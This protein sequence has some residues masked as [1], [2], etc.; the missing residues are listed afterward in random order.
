[1]AERIEE[2]NSLYERAL[3]DDGKLAELVEQL[4]Q[5]NRR[6][7]QMAGAA[8]ALVAKEAPMRLIAHASSLIEALNLPEAQTRWECLDALTLIAGCDARACDKA[9]VG[10]ETALF[11][12]DSGPV[13]LA[14][15]RFLCKYGSTTSTRSEKVWPLIDEAIQC[16]H[17]DLEFNDMLTAITDF[18]IG[19]LS[20]SVKQQLAERM[21]F[22]AVNGKG[23]LQRRAAQIV[24]NVTPK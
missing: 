15:V 17:G 7:R 2:I 3:A 8:I 20:G 19:K 1:M 9:L 11:D 6:A 24:S 14:A 22:D 12:E 23:S 4:S 5:G 21:S 18:S 16:Y 13:R 10:A